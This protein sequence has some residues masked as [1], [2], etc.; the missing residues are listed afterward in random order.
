MTSVWLDNMGLGA[1]VAKQKI[2]TLVSSPSR[3]RIKNYKSRLNSIFSDLEQCTFFNVVES[4]K[5]K[6]IV[7]I[8]TSEDDNIY[9]PC[10]KQLL[11]D[12][13]GIGAE[14]KR[15]LSRRELII[16]SG[17]AKKEMDINHIRDYIIS[18]LY[19][20]FNLYRGSEPMN[21][22]KFIRELE[23]VVTDF[24]IFEPQ[25]GMSVHWTIDA[26]AQL[27]YVD[28]RKRMSANVF[29]AKNKSG[30]LLSETIRTIE[31]RLEIP[32][33]Y[34]LPIELLDPNGTD[35]LDNPFCNVTENIEAVKNL[36]DIAKIAYHGFHHDKYR[37][38]WF[39]E[40]V[41]QDF[42]E[43]EI[44][45]GKELAKEI[46][47]ELLPVNRYPSLA[48]EPFS[49]SIL[50]KFKFQIDMSDYI[51]PD[52][53]DVF[54]DYCR[55]RLLKLQGREIV[56]SNICEIPAIFADPYI[57]DE[58]K[59]NYL[60]QRLKKGSEGHNNEFALMFHDRSIGFP[61]GDSSIFNLENGMRNRIGRRETIDRLQK[62]LIEE[63]LCKELTFGG[64][65]NG[66]GR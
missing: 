4:D 29:S 45:E 27:A 36:P 46:G 44:Y 22:C 63:G 60:M 61:E 7:E 57:F 25:K 55:Y 59:T 65:R 1:I 56:P 41:T 13:F 28:N 11:Y 62:F 19:H 18:N 50:E 39:I 3:K 33:I 32:H 23:S 15:S 21:V 16:E 43:T 49:L 26:E 58:T 54:S 6:E 8:T 5:P 48:R 51:T 42:V 24:G 64:A 35:A 38:L 66:R 31:E 53:F 52:S 37:K 10:V 14:I 2:R 34:F 40:N 20:Q 12:H 9:A 17:N 47:I 30:L